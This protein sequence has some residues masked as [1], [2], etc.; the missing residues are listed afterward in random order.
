MEEQVGLWWHRFVTQAAQTTHAE[1]AVPLDEVRRSITLLFRAGGG[2]AQVRIG[3]ASERR[4]GGPRGWLQKLAGSGTHEALPV[5]QPELL[6]LPPTLAMFAERALNREL[7]LWL[8]ALAAV[9]EPQPDWIGANLAASRAALQCFPGLREPYARLLEAQLELRPDLARLAPA[10][11]VAERLVQAA[12]RGEQLQASESAALADLHPEQV[13]PVWLWLQA[14]G[15]TLPLSNGTPAEPTAGQ[16]GA[17][18]RQDHRRR[19]AKRVEES[20]ERNAMLMFFRAESILS[21]A[22]FVKV[23]RATDDEDDGNA[24]AAANDMEQLA[25]AT[26]GATCASRVKFDLDLPSA[27][28][29]DTPLGPGERLPEWDWRAGL[30]RPDHCAVQTYVARPEGPFV[31]PLSL[32]ATAKRVRR[33]LE[34]LR[35]APHWQHGVTQGDELDLDAWV[36]ERSEDAHD[37]PRSEAP[38]VFARR[39][40]LDRS[41]AVLLLADLSLSTDAYANDQARVIDVIRDAL[42]VFGEALTATGDACAMLGFSS[43]RRQHVRLQHLKGFDERWSPAVRDRIGAIKPGYYTRLGAA[44][45]LATQRL[46]GRPERQRLLLVLTDGKPNDLDIYEGRYGLEDTRHA[47]QAARA[48]GLQPFC[49]T[50]DEAAHD[51]LPYLFG[52]QGWT[53][54]R[55]PQELVARLAQVYARLTR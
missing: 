31:P 37:G 7:Y 13:A 1:A 19:R 46:E 5:L 42:Y 45:R 36:R 47:V 18:Q 54:V 11:A 48:A 4:A 55:R 34:T 41:L 32:R 15:A 33:Q 23:N 12:L 2:A 25:L 3:E 8:A 40:R 50:I 21:W 44:I 51:Y 27:A 43:V 30:L 9:F 29:D 35:A 53:L 14:D 6:A 16:A 17:G 39:A 38:P 24:L 52:G 22:D 10:A 49:V 20:T 28:A 26:D